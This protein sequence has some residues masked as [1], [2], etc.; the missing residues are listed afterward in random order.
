[1]ILLR[2]LGDTITDDINSAIIP[3]TGSSLDFS[4]LSFSPG[5][6]LILVVAGAFLL[7]KI[8]ETKTKISSRSK[9]IQRAKEALQSAKETSIF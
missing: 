1:M 3:T 9:K 2:G 7:L 5:V 4:N 8:T 6:T